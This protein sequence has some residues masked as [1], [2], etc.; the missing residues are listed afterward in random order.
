MNF[1]DLGFQRVIIDGD[2]L[3]IVHA[4]RHENSYWSSYSQLLE[5]I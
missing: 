1:I 5:D 3:K 2:T 4:L